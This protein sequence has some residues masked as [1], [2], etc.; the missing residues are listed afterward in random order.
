[1]LLHSDLNL[2]LKKKK[3]NVMNNFNNISHTKGR[4]KE[5]E[6]YQLF[7][8]KSFVFQ[9]RFPIYDIRNSPKMLC[10][11]VLRTLQPARQRI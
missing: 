3:K 8:D 9:G 1:M 7:V 5:K 2:D 4:E 11:R 6:N 10:A